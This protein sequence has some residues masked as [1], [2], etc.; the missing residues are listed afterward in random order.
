MLRKYY[1][2][3]VTTKRSFGTEYAVDMIRMA[4]R[5]G[6]AGIAIVDRIETAKELAE[7]RKEVLDA[8]P[9]IDVLIGA[10]ITV[11]RAHKLAAKVNA[12][13]EAA[14]LIVVS[15]GDDE[16]NRAACENPR[17]DILAHPELM[18]KDG[19]IDHV[20]AGFAAKNG[21]AIELNFRGFL[22][23]YRKIRCHVLTHMRKN[24]MLAE[25][26]GAPLIVTSAAQ[27][28][29]EMRAGRDMASLASLAGL[30]T[31]RAIRTVSEIPE[32]IAKRAKDEKDPKN[33]APGVRI[34]EKK[35]QPLKE[36]E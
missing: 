15:G 28:T 1:D 31:D 32:M 30:A 12:L 2:L 18:R 9:K 29:Y 10:E 19:G 16:I 26:Y 8:K 14:D 35:E 36:A 13:R 11:D 25:K 33:V 7:A 22:Q 20:I 6:F 3:H 34:K 27:N 21:V 24:A 5:L 23:S 4:E 17:V